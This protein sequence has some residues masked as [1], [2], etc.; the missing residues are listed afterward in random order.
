MGKPDKHIR[1]RVGEEHPI[2]L[3][4]LRTAGYEWQPEVEGDEVAAV[5]KESGEEEQ[6]EAVG[7]SPDEVFKIKALKPGKALLRF[8]QRRPWESGDSA[9]DEHVVELDVS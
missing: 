7:A 6:P 3:E 5:V 1:L 9:G 8:A 2:R 4:S